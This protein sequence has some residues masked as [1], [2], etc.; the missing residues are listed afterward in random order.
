MSIQLSTAVRNAKNDALEATIGTSPKLRGYTG[1]MPANPAA[2]A[3]GTQLWEMTLP[4]DWL[5]ASSSGAKSLLGTWQDS[6]ADAAGNAGYFR[7]YDSAGTTCGLQ[8][9]V[10]ATGGGGDLTLDNINVAVNQA[11]TITSFALTEGNA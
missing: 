9:T 3:T 7:I 4:S 2:A 8:G 10:T 5:S 1:S 11:I 6:A